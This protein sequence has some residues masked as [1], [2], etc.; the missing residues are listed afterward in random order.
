MFTQVDFNKKLPWIELTSSAKDVDPNNPL[1]QK[2]IVILKEGEFYQNSV[3]NRIKELHIYSSG[4]IV[5]LTEERKIVP[6]QALSWPS[7]NSQKQMVSYV[8]H[9]CFLLSQYGENSYE[10]TSFVRGLGG[11]NGSPGGEKKPGVDEKQVDKLMRAANQYHACYITYLIKERCYSDEFVEAMIEKSTFISESDKRYN[12][13]FIE[14]HQDLYVRC[15]NSG[16]KKSIIKLVQKGVRPSPPVLIFMADIDYQLWS[17]YRLGSRLDMVRFLIEHGKPSF[18]I[19]VPTVMFRDNTRISCLLTGALKTKNLDFV[20]LLIDKGLDPNGDMPDTTPLEICQIRSDFAEVLIRAGARLSNKV[21]DNAISNNWAPNIIQLLA[22]KGLQCKD[23]KNLSTVSY[24]KGRLEPILKRGA[25]GGVFTNNTE[26]LTKALQINPESARLIIQ[27]RGCATVENLCA[28]I[29]YQ[30]TFVSWIIEQGLDK[31]LLTSDPQCLY[32]AICQNAKSNNYDTVSLLMIAK[33]AK[34][35]NYLS[36]QQVVDAFYMIPYIQALLSLEIGSDPAYLKM[37]NEFA[38]TIVRSLQGNLYTRLEQSGNLQ[39]II[40]LLAKVLFLFKG[41]C[42]LFM[43]RQKDVYIP[44][45]KLLIQETS[46]KLNELLGSEFYFDSRNNLHLQEIV[47]QL[48][49]AINEWDVRDTDA[50]FKQKAAQEHEW[51]AMQRADK[52]AREIAEARFEAARQQEEAYLIQSAQF[53]KIHND[54]QEKI[55]NL[56]RESAYIRSKIIYLELE[57]L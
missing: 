28:V 57:N 14:F 50:V 25:D 13:C 10:L 54:L 52:E 8:A 56:K 15:I 16:F 32:T 26:L 9:S 34:L 22:D 37:T 49:E 38:T 51:L 31:G 12:K 36:D 48:F 30:P 43:Q 27:E 23:A 45:R 17:E 21:L 44:K 35:E 24:D 7:F 40:S 6:V 53:E 41:V 33:G 42:V 11:G 20:M 47:E 18:K 29:T 2:T 3:Q 4:Q 5:G 1:K 19:V 55:A 46:A 39:Q